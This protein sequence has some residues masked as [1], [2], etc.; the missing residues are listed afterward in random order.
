MGPTEG[1][2]P[3]FRLSLPQPLPCAPPCLLLLVWAEPL[4]P[5][6]HGEWRAGAGQTPT[7]WEQPMGHSVASPGWALVPT[8][9]L[10]GPRA[11][12]RCSLRGSQVSLSW[13]RDSCYYHLAGSS[14]P[15]H[16]LQTEGPCRML[17]LNGV[18]GSP[19]IWQMSKMRPREGK[20]PVQ[21]HT[22]NPVFFSVLPGEE[23]THTPWF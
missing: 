4:M 7:V 6:L 8:V 22:V 1:Q 18:Q 5:G 12:S 2:A 15:S 17:R 21:G 19:P 9:F 11:T 16:L 23:N 20:G 3:R 14:A 10:S 13:Q